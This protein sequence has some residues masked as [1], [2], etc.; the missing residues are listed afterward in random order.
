M[1]DKQELEEILDNF[2]SQVEQMTGTRLNLRDWL[3]RRVEEKIQQKIGAAFEGVFTG[4]SVRELEVCKEIISGKSSNPRKQT[5]KSTKT[6]K[7]KSTKGEL[8]LEGGKNGRSKRKS[9]GKKEM[10]IK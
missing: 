9:I 2:G 7:S 3:L 4:L 6:R 5:S 1:R 8:K 10:V